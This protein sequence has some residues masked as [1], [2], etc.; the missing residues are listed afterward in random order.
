M[1][2]MVCR[3][4]GTIASNVEAIDRNLWQPG[5]NDVFLKLKDIVHNPPPISPL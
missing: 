3:D 2:V 1:V 5:R 4:F